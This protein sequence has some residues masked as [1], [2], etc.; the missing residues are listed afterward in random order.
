M[1]P[2]LLDVT[3]EEI[4]EGEMLNFNKKIG[5]K[6][7]KEGFYLTCI[8]MIPLFFCGFLLIPVLDAV[9]AW[10]EST[11][12]INI[13]DFTTSHSRVSLRAETIDI[14]AEPPEV[15]LITVDHH[16]RF[17]M[18]NMAIIGEE[19]MWIPL[20]DYYRLHPGNNLIEYR[21]SKAGF[22]D[23]PTRSI[24]LD[25]QKDRPKTMDSFVITDILQEG[26]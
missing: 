6:G 13:P 7:R 12:E 21:A 1:L 10:A 25:L 26:D 15:W 20:G 16:K 23:G 11:I 2:R 14:N 9:F 5:R 8:I 22:I 24:V 18:P 3:E 19:G 17:I 4:E